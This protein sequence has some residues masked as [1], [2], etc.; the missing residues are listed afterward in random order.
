MKLNTLHPWRSLSATA[1]LLLLASC[2]QNTT[3]PTKDD[4]PASTPSSSDVSKEQRV[5]P[6]AFGAYWYTGEAELTSYE[7]EQAR[8]GE[9]REG[10]AV[11]IYVTEPFLEGKQVK[12]D[13]NHPN[14]IQV[15][16]LNNTKKFL[17]GIYP[18]SIMT[19]IFYPVYA[20][21]HAIKVSASIQEWCGHVYTQLNNREAFELTSHSYFEKEADQQLRLDKTPLE[22]EIWTQLRIAPES[23][24]LGKVQMLPALEYIRLAHKEI[25]A[26]AAECSLTEAAGLSTYKISY[27][28]LE[29]TLSIQFGTA[30]PHVVEG[31]SESHSSGFG[32]DARVLTSR[33]TKLHTLK[34]AY[35]EKNGN[36]DVILRDSLG[37]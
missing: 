13:Q 31:W 30:F 6:K 21:E 15:L 16:K 27:P 19:S 36:K 18:Y 17:T 28:E 4:T 1:V 24:P 2:G 29:R 3:A 14:N 12:A 8:Y 10:H 9:I 5:L 33:A 34:T 37:L 7:L 20:Q 25:K 22:D 26:Y 11:L 23:L 32:P 35:W